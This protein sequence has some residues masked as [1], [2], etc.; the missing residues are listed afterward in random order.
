[1]SLVLILLS[2]FFLLL[3]LAPSLT[4]KEVKYRITYMKDYMVKIEAGLEEDAK[5][6]AEARDRRI[7]EEVRKHSIVI[8]A[9][10]ITAFV[11]TFIGITFIVITF[12]VITLRSFIASSDLSS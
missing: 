8:T 12:I 3:L 9:I 4:Q 7:E 10:V 6:Q 11:I 1:M 5:V 2:P